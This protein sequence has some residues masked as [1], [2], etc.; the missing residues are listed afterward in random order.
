MYIYIWPVIGV[1]KAHIAKA[2]EALG[3]AGAG[4]KRHIY[5]YIYI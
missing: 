5:I 4:K 1:S 3:A 2:F